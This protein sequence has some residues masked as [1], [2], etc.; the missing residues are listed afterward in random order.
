MHTVGTDG[1]GHVAPV[2]HDEPSSM[3]LHERT[4]SCGEV[5]ELAGAH[6]FHP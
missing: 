4:E 2:I 6:G 1:Q 5:V 3:P